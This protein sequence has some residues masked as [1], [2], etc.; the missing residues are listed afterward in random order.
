MTDV[1]GIKVTTGR[2]GHAPGGVWLH[3]AVGGGRALHGR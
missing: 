2:S 3:L 1:L